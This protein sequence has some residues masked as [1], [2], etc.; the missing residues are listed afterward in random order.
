MF[1]LIRRDRDHFL[2]ATVLLALGG[3]LAAIAVL[4]HVGFASPINEHWQSALALYR[5]QGFAFDWYG[6]FP[7]PVVGSFL[8]PLYAWV[9][10]GLLY[11]A[12][13]SAPEAMILSQVLNALLG[14]ATVWL[15]ARLA[16]RAAASM[17]VGDTPTDW[18]H[19]T[20]SGRFGVSPR[21][22]AF[23]RLGATLRSL[24]PG[25]L[26]A[27]AWAVYP[28]ALGHAATPQSTLI[29]TFLLM[30][31]LDLV[32]TGS[33]R[34]DAPLSSCP[35]TPEPPAR[36]LAPAV[37][38]GMVLGLSLLSRPTLGIAW[39]FWIAAALS[40]VF[41]ARRRHGRGARRLRGQGARRAL[42]FYA[43]ATLVAFAV[44]LPW[45]ARNARLHGRLIPIATNGGFNFYMGNNPIWEGGIPPLV[46]YFPRMTE[47]ERTAWRA[48]SEVER[49][50]HFYR[51]GLEYWRD[52]PGRAL[53]GVW[54]RLVSFALWRPYLFAAYPRWLAV[55]FIASYVV[56]LGPFLLALPRCRGP[57]CVLP[58]LAILAT[59][60]T[61]LAFVVSMR[62]RATVEPMLVALGATVAARPIRPRR[63]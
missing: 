7:R 1:G 33:E 17:A 37:A 3:R 20:I 12:G 18:I 40:G 6:L 52:Q 63:W 32:L 46:K 53:L 4:N 34:C 56:A 8:P 57:A 51:M 29:E 22:P 48:L 60:V 13:G 16:D 55:L 10:C 59:A 25:R 28:P 50:R 5:G 21:V 35:S 2:V 41:A 30:S 11:V 43:V 15:V 36:L 23:G 26:A 24:T 14:A 49:D 58:I 9:L 54:H 38:A 45:T 19:R 31:L 42:R 44:V 62:F 47:E 39:T 61:G 27:L